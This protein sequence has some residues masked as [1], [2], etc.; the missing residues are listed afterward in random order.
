MPKLS[1]LPTIRVLAALRRA[2][3]EVGGGAKHYKLIHPTKPGA[4]AVPWSSPLKIGTLR[5]I[6]KQAGLTV[7]EFH[8]LYR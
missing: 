1:E 2:G 8:K 5:A 6:I 4:L 3:W 7:D